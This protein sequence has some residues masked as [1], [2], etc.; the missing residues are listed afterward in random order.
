MAFSGLSSC[1]FRTV[2]VT[3]P[4]RRTLFISIQNIV[5]PPTALISFKA[6]GKVHLQEEQVTPQ[7]KAGETVLLRSNEHFSVF[8]ASSSR[9]WGEERSVLFWFSTSSTVNIR[10]PWGER[11]IFFSPDEHLRDKRHDFTLKDSPA[12]VSPHVCPA[13]N[14]HVGLWSRVLTTLRYYFSVS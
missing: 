8:F 11:G 13:P 10:T 3:S 4:E 7:H 9:S 5:T 14:A 1:L 6:Y 2:R 12:S